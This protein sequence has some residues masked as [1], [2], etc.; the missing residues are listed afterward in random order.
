MEIAAVLMA[1]V[2]D[3]GL[4]GFP[5]GMAHGCM[6]NRPGT[7]AREAGGSEG[8]QWVWLQEPGESE[9][10]SQASGDLIKDAPAS[11]DGTVPSR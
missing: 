9:S 1:V 2:V 6:G 5:E 4:V 8:T 11:P 10:L 7:Q 3:F